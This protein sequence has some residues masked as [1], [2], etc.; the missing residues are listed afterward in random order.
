MLGIGYHQLEEAFQTPID[1]QPVDSCT[2]HAHM[3][4]SCLQQPGTQGQQIGRFI[5]ERADLFA[6]L[7]C[8]D[9]RETHHQKTQMHIDTRAPLIHDLHAPLSFLVR[10]VPP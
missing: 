8:F 10:S 7:S 1:V 6:P 3:G 5:A 2:L 9:D 4:T